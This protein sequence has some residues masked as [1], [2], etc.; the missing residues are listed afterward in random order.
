MSWNSSPVW[1]VENTIACAPTD[2]GRAAF[3]LRRCLC[4]QRNGQHEKEH[5]ELDL[6]RRGAS[7]PTATKAPHRCARGDFFASV[8]TVETEPLGKTEVN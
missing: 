7:S 4:Q 8:H 6:V 5:G 3:S 2:L 1:D